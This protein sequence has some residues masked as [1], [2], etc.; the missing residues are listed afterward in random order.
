MVEIEGYAAPSE[1]DPP[2]YTQVTK[3]TGAQT[4]LFI[5]A[6]WPTTTP[7]PPRGLCAGAGGRPEWLVEI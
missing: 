6:S 1:H 4:I 5:P 7:G 3:V 2:S